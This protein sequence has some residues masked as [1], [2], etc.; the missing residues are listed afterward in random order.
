MI[1][2]YVD[3]NI[4]LDL[5]AR[6]EP[7]YIDAAVLFTLADQK[8]IKVSASAL[9]IANVAYILRRQ[10]SSEELTSILKKLLLLLN[11]L[12]LDERVVNHA[13]VNAEFADFED[14]LQYYTAIDN[15]QNIIITRNLKDYKNS[16]LP[17]MTAAQY[18][19]S[20]ND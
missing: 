8:K 15:S 16:K 7:F 3:T 1:K 13:L 6:R 11:I 14:C 5:L 17:V 19:S 12:P 20:F 2:V 18:L 9:T 4:V 10:L